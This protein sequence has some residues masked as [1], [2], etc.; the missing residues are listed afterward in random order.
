MARAASITIV[1]VDEPV[2]DVGE[3]DPDFVHTPGVF[4]DRVVVVPPDGIQEVVG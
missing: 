3:I 1:E 2:V 4:V